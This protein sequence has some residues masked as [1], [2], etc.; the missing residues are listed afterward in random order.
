[1]RPKFQIAILSLFASL[2]LASVLIS[3]GF[4][5][6]IFSFQALSE[7]IP[8]QAIVDQNEF[9]QLKTTI[10]Y[11]KQS[12]HVQP[13][14]TQAWPFFFFLALALASIASILVYF[15][16]WASLSYAWIASGILLWIGI[17]FLGN[18]AR[19]IHAIYAVVLEQ[20]MWFCILSA[21]LCTLYISSSL[22]AFAFELGHSQSRSDSLKNWIILYGIIFVNVLFSLGQTLGWWEMRAAIP[23][24]IWWLVLL[25]LFLFR[26]PKNGLSIGLALSSFAIVMMY[27]LLENDPGLSAFFQWTLMTQAMMTILFPLFLWQN[28][29]SAFAQNLP[30]YKILHKAPHLSLNT[31]HVGILILGVGWIFANQG[32]II[33]QTRAAQANT[34]GD[35][36]TLLADYPNAE[37][38][39]QQALGHSRLN[40]KS[41]TSLAKLALL[42]KDQET[43]AYYL[44]TAQVKKPNA[45]A[46]VA[47][48][49][50]YTENKQPFQA[51][52]ALQKANDNFPNNLHI[53]TA[54]A[55]AYSFL[56]M[57]DS[58]RYWFSEAYEQHP[59][60]EIAQGNA[61]FATRNNTLA[62][63]TAFLA[64]QAN[65]IAIALQAGK[66]APKFPID[67]AL[68][69]EDDLRAWAFL[70]NA[71][72]YGKNKGPRF[73]K[74]PQSPIFP[75]ATLIDA[76]QD[77][78]HGKPLR[79][80]EKL[81]V[82]IIQ[83]TSN[84][85]TG[86]QNILLFWQKSLRIPVACPRVSNVN[87]AKKHL[88][89]YPFQVPV[90]TE[91]IQILNKAKQF[92]A[93]YQ[94]ALSAL[95]WN[96]DIAVYILIYAFQ[97]LEMGEL[98]YAKQAMETLKKKDFP[99][100]EANQSRFEA[101][102]AQAELK[103]KTW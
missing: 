101:A 3:T 21:G 70:Y 62:V 80:L 103:Q 41:N 64:N 88:E 60:D 4:H 14:A 102:V 78:Y 32:R 72:L 43:A 83:E 49:H 96:E 63:N 94:A 65:Q 57:N 95:Q 52:F 17:I 20:L 90:L 26:A 37:F 1:M 30:V 97:A 35:F 12:F 99:V 89:K 31:L 50:I 2:G 77:Y 46:A 24:H 55:H 11:I 75:E 48:A 10:F 54:L 39:Y 5:P 87:E 56:S 38:T 71:S 9:G 13:N 67:S 61:L 91:S 23:G 100:Y 16:T 58:A 86:Y 8:E 47:M 42:A 98:G 81:N 7:L 25:G 22:L 74:I 29:G 76:W 92:K 82:A 19:D 93:G 79:A 69:P 28:F 36:Y 66:P 18:Q 85:I 53:E 45:L 44:A 84:R 59:D 33:H 51:L 27:Q 40:V 6:T 34:L 15:K 68:N 73:T